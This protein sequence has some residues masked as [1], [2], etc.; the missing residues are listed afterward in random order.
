[1]RKLIT[2]S[3]L[4]LA[5]CSTTQQTPPISSDYGTS[6][7]AG[8]P[9]AMEVEPAVAPNAMVATDAP[10]ATEAGVQ[11]LRDGGNAVDAAVTTAF[12]LAVVYPE[13][14]NIGGGGFMVAHMADGTS[15]ALDFREK[16]PLASTRD[17]YLDE[18]GELT[19][20]S[21]TGHLASG[22]PGAVMGLWQA[23]Q[24]F[25]TKPWAELLAPAISLARDGFIV[26]AE[27]AA[28]V[29][30]EADRLSRFPGSAALFLPN[31][32]PLRE[33]SRWSNPDIAR[34]LERVA[35]QGPAGFYEG[36]T[37]DLIVAEM[38]RGGGII[39]H[40]DLRRYE[41]EWREPVEFDYRGRRVISMPPASSGGITL[42]IMA[43]ILDGYDMD[44][45]GWHSASALHVTGEAM[46]RAFADRNHFL[47]DP[48]FVELPRDL[49][50]SQEYA[51][52]LRAT[53]QPDRATPSTD[54]RPGLMEQTEPTQTTHFSIVDEAGN[55]VALT[56]TINALYGSAVAVT[57][58]GFMLNDEMDDFAAKPGTP[59]MFG[60]VQGEA[61]AIEPEKRM[62]SAM[63]PTIVVDT[64]ARVLLVTGA[65]G[66]PRIITAVFQVMTNIIDYGM[67]VGAAVHAPR[68]HHQHLPDI[69]YFERDGLTP[70]VVAQLEA[71]GHDVEPRGGIGTA[72][73]ILRRDGVWTAV[74]DP[75]TGGLASGY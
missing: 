34:V 38:Q 74:P 42:A 62:L 69:L 18:T 37:A 2:L 67:D 68:I 11:V 15:A 10:L 13:A 72:P 41:A 45:M 26:D 61:N 59:N 5:A 53:I 16:A 56:T 24:R 58:A 36:E 30:G 51:D 57:G 12:V 17:M 1:M 31:G 7:P 33:G 19:D 9:F 23:H 25:G 22:V 20:R 8:W 66:G 40:E 39:T 28:S 35:A 54:I 47:G 71:M 49:L 29:R 14:G 21:V 73:T 6:I 63:T 55:A 44:D 75:R 3:L 60:L 48:A 65:R 46:R 32:E 52:R 43:N 64:D 4:A 70:E 50:V 27:F